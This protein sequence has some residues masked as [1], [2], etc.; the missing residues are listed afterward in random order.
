MAHELPAGLFEVLEHAAI[1]DPI[2]SA[3]P[4]ALWRL[5]RPPPRL[6][7]TLVAGTAFRSE[8]DIFRVP[9]SDDCGRPFS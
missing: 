7:P 4:S 8:E 5:M 2:A 9:R 1:E 6:W 3:K